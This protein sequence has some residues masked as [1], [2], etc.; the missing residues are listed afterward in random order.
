VISPRVRKGLYYSVPHAGAQ[1]GWGR[2][3]AY[4]AA[5]TGAIPVK[6]EGKL[7]LVPRKIWDRR[8]RQMLRGAT[9]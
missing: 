3:Q 9:A 5:A 4:A 6:R 2:S 1:V 8:V 7:L